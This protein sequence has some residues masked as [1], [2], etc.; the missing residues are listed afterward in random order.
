MDLPSKPFFS[1][2]SPHRITRALLLWATPL[3][4]TASLWPL[5]EKK[6]SFKDQGDWVLRCGGVRSSL[7]IGL[8]NR[9]AELRMFFENMH[10]P[11]ASI[12][13]ASSTLG[14]I[15]NLART[16]ISPIS[17]HP[18][19][20]QESRMGASIENPWNSE[21]VFQLSTMQHFCQPWL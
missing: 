21:S 17:K 15:I 6:G 18:S 7:R 3:A 11:Y 19:V 10:Q 1:L 8:S 9:F 14:W 13:D 16:P 12:L 2:P 4:P 5:D 20:S